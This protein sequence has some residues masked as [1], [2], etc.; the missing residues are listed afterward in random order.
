MYATSWSVL[1]AEPAK[2]TTAVTAAAAASPPEMD[3]F[4]LRSG[5]TTDDGTENLKEASERLLLLEK[6]ARFAFSRRLNSSWHGSR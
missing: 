2:S 1:S 6:M 4:F 3:C 5:G